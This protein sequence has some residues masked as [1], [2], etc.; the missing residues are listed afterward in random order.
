MG[1]LRSELLERIQLPEEVEATFI[2]ALEG[3]MALLPREQSCR[4]LHANQY[5]RFTHTLEGQHT[6][7]TENC[8]LLF[9]VGAP[10]HVAR[11]HPGKKLCPLCLRPIFHSPP[12][13][14]FFGV[15]CI[16]FFVLSI[17]LLFLSFEVRH[18]SFGILA[19]SA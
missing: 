13:C 14:E 17:V 8:S 18:D 1:R 5:V 16:C 15:V 2:V 12:H 7:L 4:T 19:F 10:M 3:R 6:H 11:K 9:L